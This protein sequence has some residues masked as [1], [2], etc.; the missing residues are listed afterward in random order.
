MTQLEQP[1]GGH[2]FGLTSVK[3][4]MIMMDPSERPTPLHMGAQVSWRVPERVHAR[5]SQQHG[6]L[7]TSD[8]REMTN[9][10]SVLTEAVTYHKGMCLLRCI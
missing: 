2:I 8:D 1:I 10:V 9:L 6:Q 4:M 7:I 3:N 5:H